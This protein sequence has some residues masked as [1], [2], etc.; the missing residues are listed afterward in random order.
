MLAY[1]QR[2]RYQREVQAAAQAHPSIRIAQPYEPLIPPV[3]G[4]ALPPY[5]QRMMVR[6]RFGRLV[7]L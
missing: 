4:N 3:D 6:D 2:K 5:G 7:A 1:A